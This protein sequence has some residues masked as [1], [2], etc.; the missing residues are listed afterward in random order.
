MWLASHGEVTLCFLSTT[1]SPEDTDFLRAGQEP[2]QQLTSAYEPVGLTVSVQH[3]ALWAPGQEATSPKP[4]GIVWIE[5]PHLQK[6]LTVVTVAAETQ[7]L[8]TVPKH[9]AP[10]RLARIHSEHTA[11]WAEWPLRAAAETSVV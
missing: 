1:H 4:T 9:G 8:R 7:Q 6:V 2:P 5:G 11:T 3:T 10:L